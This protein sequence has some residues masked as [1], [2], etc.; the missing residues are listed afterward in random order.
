MDAAAVRQRGDRKRDARRLMMVGPYVPLRHARP[1]AG[2]PRLQSFSKKGVDGRD[3]GERSDAVL[4]TAMP[5]HDEENITARAKPCAC[6]PRRRRRRECRGVGATHRRS[7]DC[8][9]RALRGELARREFCGPERP[10]A[11]Q[12]PL[13]ARSPAPPLTDRPD[14]TRSP[15]Q[16]ARARTRRCA[17]PSR[18]SRLRAHHLPQ[19]QQTLQR[20][21]TGP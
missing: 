16:A 14:G 20:R 15:V 7:A 17:N 3:I 11:G 12:H 18:S 19:R 4:R 13:V 8:A 10:W 1:R 9:A 21:H 6:R 5:G 2:H